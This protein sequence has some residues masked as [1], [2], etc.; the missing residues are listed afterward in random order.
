MKIVKDNI[1]N[2]II[3]NLKNYLVFILVLIIYILYF[4]VFKHDESN[5]LIKRMIGFPCPGCGMTRAVY[6]LLTLRWKQAFYYHPFVFL[7]PLLIVLFIEKGTSL[8]DMFLYSK[9]FWF[10]I[11]ILFIGIYVV[12]MFLYFPNTIPMDYYDDAYINFLR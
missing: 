9:R 6:Y 1:K 11:F 2:I 10:I 4:V 3:P 5:C 12:R 8:A 7:L